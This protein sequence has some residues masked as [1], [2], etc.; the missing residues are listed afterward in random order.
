MIDAHDASLYRLAHRTRGVG[1]Y[2][3]ASAT[4]LRGFHRRTQFREGVLRNIQW[5]VPRC[6]AA[7]GHQLDLRCAQC[8]LFASTLANRVGA[9]G[10]RGCTRPLAEAERAGR[11]RQYVR[12]SKVAMVTGLR[13]QS[14]YGPHPRSG[15]INRSK[16][17]FRL[18]E[19]RASILLDWT[20]CKRR[21]VLG[22]YAAIHSAT[23]TYCHLSDPRLPALLTASASSG[24]R[25]LPVS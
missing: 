10:D 17:P 25:L 2:R 6:H 16:L 7:A 20:P 24:D 11:C 1:V 19:R 8:Q 18:R 4:V 12:E 15:P 14:P 21:R 23:D 13:N 5:V 9:V 3:D 22:L